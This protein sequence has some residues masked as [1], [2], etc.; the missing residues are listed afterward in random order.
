MRH[1][2]FFISCAQIPNPLVVIMNSDL[3]ALKQALR[4]RETELQQLMRQMK[5][6]Q[7]N[8]SKVY[9]NLEHELNGIK[10][11][12]QQETSLGKDNA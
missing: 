10:M 2:V 6:D 5:S 4:Q 1:Y 9:R 11:Q 12:I 8:N 3:K 7:L